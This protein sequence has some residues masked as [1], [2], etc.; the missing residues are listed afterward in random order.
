MKRLLIILTIISTFCVAPVLGQRGQEAHKK[1]EVKKGLFPSYIV[2]GRKIKRLAELERIVLSI[3]D[4]ETTQLFKKSKSLQNTSKPFSWIG[5][6]LMGWAIGGALGG[7]EFDTPL[8]ASGC[9]I[10]SFGMFL[11]VKA[12]KNRI[13]SVERY[14]SI[15]KDKW[16]I[17][18]QYLPQNKKLKLGF[19]YSFK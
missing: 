15:L 18:L 3:N 10:A 13:K 2:D 12:D 19:H 1:I 8:F 9:A 14:N 6:F 5:G 11:G 7:E 16:G 17:S 4:E